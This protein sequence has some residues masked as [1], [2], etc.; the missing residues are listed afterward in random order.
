MK[1]S[2]KYC[3]YI[4][5]IKLFKLKNDFRVQ[6]SLSFF[7]HKHAFITENYWYG[8]LLEYII[9]IVTFIITQII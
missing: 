2:L 8:V 5:G 9:T 3:P 4:I 7:F 6:R 1:S